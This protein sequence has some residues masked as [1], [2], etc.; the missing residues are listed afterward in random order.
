[1]SEHD[2]LRTG[3]QQLDSTLSLL[4]RN[5]NILGMEGSRMDWEDLMEWQRVLLGGDPD[6]KPCNHL[7]DG[8]LYDYGYTTVPTCSRCNA[9]Q[10]K[11]FRV[12]GL[13]DPQ[14]GG[15]KVWGSDGSVDDESPS[16]AQAFG[17]DLW[18]GVK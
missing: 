13:P 15:A 3:L 9:L 11:P 17:M 10:M 1:M 12:A 8:P 4:D 16:P 7:W 6:A 14:H 5:V 2:S 18:S